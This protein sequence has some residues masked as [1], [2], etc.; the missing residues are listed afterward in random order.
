MYMLLE[1]AAIT[2]FVFVLGAIFFLVGILLALVD[3]G[4]RALVANLR[5]GR[6]SLQSSSLSLGKATLT[7]GIAWEGTRHGATKN[8]WT[9]RGSNPRPHDCQLCISVES[10]RYAICDMESS[11]VLPSA[12]EC[13]F[14]QA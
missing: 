3:A 9:W 5:T 7:T 1:G 10:T 12:S 8:W 11:K 2:G 14:T 4:G 6:K 13:L